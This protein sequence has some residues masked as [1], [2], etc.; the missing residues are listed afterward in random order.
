MDIK[1]VNYI[2]ILDREGNILYYLDD[3]KINLKEFL[4]TFTTAPDEISLYD[5]KLCLTSIHGDIIIVLLATENANEIFVKKSFDAFIQ[6]LDKIVKTWNLSTV[7]EKYD[8]IVIAFNSF[9][10]HG[11]ILTDDPDVLKQSIPKRSFESI[12]GIKFKKGFAS[13]ISKTTKYAK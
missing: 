4:P 12:S 7:F 13:F 3:S 5:G 8:Q 2:G 11:V 9:V 10:F 6:V 1:D